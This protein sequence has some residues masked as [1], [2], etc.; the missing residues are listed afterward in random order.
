MQMNRVQDVFGSNLDLWNTFHLCTTNY[1]LSLLKVMLV[2]VL[3]KK[4]TNRMCVIIYIKRFI[5]SNWLTQLWSLG[6]SKLQQWRLASW[7]LRKELQLRV[8]RQSAVEPGITT[9]ADEVQRWCS[10]EFLLAW[11]R[12]SLFFYLGF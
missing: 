7:R 9:V 4:R 1:T 5:L 10:G 11:G 2:R 8:Q 6:K 3:Q 12:V